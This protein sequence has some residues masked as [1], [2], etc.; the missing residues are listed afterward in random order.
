[1]IDTPEQRVLIVDD[2]ATIRTKLS[3]AVEV[4]GYTAL[5]SVDAIQAKKQL[6]NYRIDLI[7]L[8]IEMP[9]QNGLELLKELKA[10]QQ[11]TGIPVLI[12]S[13]LD[14]ERDHVI[15][16]LELGA[17][18]FLPKSVPQAILR[19][20]I[21]TALRIKLNLDRENEKRRHVK[22]LTMAAALL[23]EANYNPE[24]LHLESTMERD[25]ELGR[26]ARVFVSMAQQLYQ[27]ERRLRHRI[28]T[29]RSFGLMLVVG[30]LCGL[31][32]PLA[33]YAASFDAQSSGISLWVATVICLAT[34]PLA[35]YRRDF[36]P[37]S[38]YSLRYF[39]IWGFC[40]VVLGDY[41]LLVVAEHLKASV[42]SVLLMTEVSMV[43][44]YSWIVRIE[45]ST[46][47]RFAGLL[48][49]LLGVLMIV[50]NPD[51]LGE[52]TSLTWLLI[53]LLVPL[54]FAVIDVLSATGRPM[55]LNALTRTGIASFFG[56]LMIL[57]IAW[58]QDSFVSLQLIPGNLE[59]LILFWG[60]LDTVTVATIF[61]VVRST[62]AVFGSQIAYVQMVMGILLSLFIL[63][64][65]L[66]VQTWIAFCV[67]LVGMLL[68]EPKR[69]AELEIPDDA[70]VSIGN[71][72]VISKSN[73]V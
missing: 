34:L 9:G 6:A 62:G 59:F 57:P 60:L 31:D 32:A 63:G 48:I 43:F 55:K 38:W 8:D 67:I 49:G 20:R 39:M 71:H 69:E 7:L 53:A 3:C 18:D 50:I 21:K 15:K 5:T 56:L 33:R 4:L 61:I 65:S 72:P 44:L 36:P 54:G 25:D 70:F 30:A 28:R 26:F 45:Q 47:K 66:S 27:R 40:A 2:Q 52:T 17:I 35:I 23:D 12:I 10:S 24:H 73:T 37:L 13:A 46:G 58:A 64:E 42:L 19:A 22:S 51:E 68:V 11:Y 29:M 41:F 1:M 14:K 16:A